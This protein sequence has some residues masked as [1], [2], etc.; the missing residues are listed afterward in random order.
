MTDERL[1]RALAVLGDAG[2]DV[3]VLSD[4][5]TLAY[6]AGYEVP[7]EIGPSPF[8]GGPPVAVVTRE[9]RVSLVASTAEEPAQPSMRIDDVVLYPGFSAE[10]HPR[11]LG[12]M[13]IEAVAAAVDSSAIVAV[14][15]RTLPH[16][17]A[18]ALGARHRLVEVHEPLAQA[19]VHKTAAEVEA[20]RV[21]AALARVGQN[22]AREAAV[23]GRTGF[24]VFA[25]VRCAMEKHADR[26][27]V[28][29]A[30]LLTGGRETAAA[31]GGPTRRVV[32]ENDPVLC[33]LAPRLNGYWGDG[34]TTF[35][36]GE[37]T[38]E[39]RELFAIVETAL[40]RAGEVLR[41]GVTTGAIDRELRWMLDGSGLEAPLHMGH[42]IGVAEHEYPRVVPG[43]S[44]LLEEDMV[45][46]LEPYVRSET[47]GVRLESMF[48]ITASG[49]ELLSDYEFRL[50]R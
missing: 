16:S 12:D 46:M 20:L 40:R 35:C 30:D 49:N 24:D 3:A 36:V 19:R 26:R 15:G 47:C 28:L 5:G 2:A 22:A 39:L 23:P 33:D 4:V 48:R 9:G 25:A 42:G 6:V 13:Y 44:A 31:M 37:P 29:D 18:E 7:V 41:P 50:E 1:Q 17:L 34:C 10:R 14:E 45:I 11:A 27:L 38:D 32:A 8:A 21:A 43:E